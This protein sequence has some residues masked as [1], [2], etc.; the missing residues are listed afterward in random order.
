MPGRC[1]NGHAFGTRQCV[2]FSRPVHGRVCVSVGRYMCVSGLGVFRWV[3]TGPCAFFSGAVQGRVLEPAQVCDLLKGVILIACCIIMNYMD[4]SM[5]YHLIRGQAIIKLYIFFNMLEVRT[6]RQG[7]W[8][9]W[10]TFV[11]LCLIT[12]SYDVSGWSY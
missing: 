2:H 6:G 12:I 7:S 8:V 3:G 4:V 11:S 9:F 1:T 5:M 10:Q